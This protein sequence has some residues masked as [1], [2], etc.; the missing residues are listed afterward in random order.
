MVML[1]RGDE[2]TR[3]NAA[4]LVAAGGARISGAGVE[5]AGSLP[6]ERHAGQGIY[7]SVPLKRFQSYLLSMSTFK[8]FDSPLVPGGNS[9]VLNCLSSNGTSRMK[10]ST[11]ARSIVPS[12]RP[13]IR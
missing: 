8:S 12:G 11:L 13:C 5:C 7:S 6:E 10:E 4:G 3:T 2:R 1:G 9:S